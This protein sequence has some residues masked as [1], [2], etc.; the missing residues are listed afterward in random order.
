M[1]VDVERWMQQYFDAWR[2]NDPGDVAALFTMDAVYAVGPF[3]GLWRGRDEI[4]ERWTAG[5]GTLL[6]DNHEVLATDGDTAVV[7]WN[8]VLQLTHRR[9]EED[10]LLVLMFAADGR[11]RE[12]REWFVE[13]EPPASRRPRRVD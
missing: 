5:D 3:A 8:V 10:G 1:A 6:E 13:R 11:C 4:V 9:L 2:S 12:H 7:H